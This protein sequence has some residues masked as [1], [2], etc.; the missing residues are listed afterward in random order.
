MDRLEQS[1]CV[2]ARGEVRA[3]RHPEAALERRREVGEDVAEQVRGDDDVDRARIAN[4]PR[5]ERVDEDVFDADLRERRADLHEHLIPEREAVARRV[6]LGRVRQHTF[7]PRGELERSA[8]DSLAASAGED[9]RLDR[10]LV[11]E[12]R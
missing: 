4:D 12:G 3:R 11:L 7:A 2:A 5:R 6:R 8:D 9:G 1:G 10:N